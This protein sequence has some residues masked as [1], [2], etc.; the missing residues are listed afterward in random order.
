MKEIS[1]SRLLQDMRVMASQARGEAK[2]VIAELESNDSFNQV[3]K[4]A[5]DELNKLQQTSTDL[6]QRYTMG[7]PN[8]TLV[9]AMVAGQKAGL[10]FEATV[11]VRNKLVQAYQDIMSMPI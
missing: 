10:A 1:N 8:V 4:K 11:Q 5:L 7:D 6:K 9:D 3:F 2:T